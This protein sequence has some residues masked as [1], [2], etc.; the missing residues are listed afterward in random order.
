M[1]LWLY[2]GRDLKGEPF[3]DTLK[4]TERADFIEGV[5]SS[6]DLKDR[7]L[8]IETFSETGRKEE[9]LKALA[10][11]K[12]W[13]GTVASLIE[14]DSATYWAIQSGIGGRFVG[15]I[16]AP[17]AGKGGSI[18][19]LR[20][21]ITDPGALDIAANA[22][23]EL[24]L[25]VTVCRDQAGGILSRV[26]A[27][28]INEAAIMAQNGIASVDKIDNM[29]RLAANFPMGP[30]E[31]ADKIGLDRLLNLLENL[32]KE[33]GP[34]YQPCPMIRRKVEAGKLG[35]KTGEGFY[36]YAEGEAQ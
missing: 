8:V 25:L 29:M 16:S 11:C 17:G 33:F 12:D 24:E 15:F 19:L 36:N 22:F 14:R 6:G 35:V 9:V 2:T 26:L 23:R 28:M 1:T 20:G 13:H 7:E 32:T 30:F 34:I 3:W 4:K 10:E 31:W 18:E 21:E 27:G 5:P